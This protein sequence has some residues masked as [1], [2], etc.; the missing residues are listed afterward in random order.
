MKKIIVVLAV[1]F[2]A[3]PALAQ[4]LQGYGLLQ[5]YQIYQFDQASQSSQA[6][7]S[8]RYYQPYQFEQPQQQPQP[9]KPKASKRVHAYIGADLP[10][11]PADTK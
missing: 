6:D 2:F 10:D 11:Q 5:P 7:Q 4:D 9:S 1:L 3:A 8:I